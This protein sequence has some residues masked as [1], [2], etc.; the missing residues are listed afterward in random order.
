MG[1]GWPEICEA[2][3]GLRT[4]KLHIPVHSR[5]SGK[6]LQFG[7]SGIKVTFKLKG[8]KARAGMPI[9]PPSRAPG[10]P[11]TQTSL[12][13]LEA[14]FLLSPPLFD[15]G[16]L[17]CDFRKRCTGLT[18]GPVTSPTFTFLIQ[19]TRVA[20]PDLQNCGALGRSCALVQSEC[21]S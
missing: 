12:A 8:G 6:H 14:T 16:P 19:K 10:V 2:R 20:V 1:R 7:Y 11:G 5:G 18:W 9:S 13:V 21:W 15:T 3:A 17:T 4:W